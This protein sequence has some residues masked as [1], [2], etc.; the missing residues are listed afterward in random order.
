[1]ELFGVSTQELVIIVL[2]VLVIFGP[3]RLP[4]LARH[5]GRV[6]RMFR[7]ASDE[8]RR[9]LDM[10]L[11][12]LPRPRDFRVELDNP[13]ERE[14]QRRFGRREEP[15]PEAPA[16]PPA[17]PAPPAEPEIPESPGETPPDD[18]PASQEKP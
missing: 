3:H 14:Y 2:V 6:T 5:L 12:D 13:F 4:E 9:N 1:M 18:A 15:E 10:N 11:D 17:L 7:K 8:L 16:E